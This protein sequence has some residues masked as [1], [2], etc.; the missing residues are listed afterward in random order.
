MPLEG[1]V[2]QK[3]SQ[4]LTLVGLEVSNELRFLAHYPMVN[5]TVRVGHNSLLY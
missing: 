2:G 5:K 4:L 3:L 1:D